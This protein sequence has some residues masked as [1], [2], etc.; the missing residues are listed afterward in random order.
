[1][2]VS[3]II[4]FHEA[5][6]FRKAIVL[7]YSSQ[8]DVRVSSQ[9]P[10]IITCHI[11]QAIVDYLSPVVTACVLNQSKDHRFFNDALN[12]AITMSSKLKEDVGIVQN[13]D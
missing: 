2:F 11:S 4:L 3:K 8:I 9:I 1:M 10:P 5:L 7:Y 13:L 6:L 12:S